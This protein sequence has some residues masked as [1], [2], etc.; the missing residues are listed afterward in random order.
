[1]SGIAAYVFNLQ[2]I[3]S[4]EDKE[5]EMYQ[6]ALDW[7]WEHLPVD[8]PIGPDDGDHESNLIAVVIEESRKRSPLYSPAD[9]G[10]DG[11]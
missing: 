3:Q 6:A 11:G 4:M 5:R 10:T 8:Q 2:R 1:V 7:M 9:G